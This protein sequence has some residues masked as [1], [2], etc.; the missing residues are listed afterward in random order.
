MN[1]LD[2][3]CMSV[4]YSVCVRIYIC[5]YTYYIRVCVYICM[6]MYICMCVCMYMYIYVY[7]ICVCVYICMYVC[8]H[9][10]D[11]P[12]AYGSSQARDQTH[13]SAAT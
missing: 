3:Q 8:V 9:F 6:Y 4:V 11:T 10:I 13:T 1:I 7:Y 12:A 5:I 2:L